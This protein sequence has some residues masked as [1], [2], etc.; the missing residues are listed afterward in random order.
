ML[1]AARRD[2]ITLPETP[3]LFDD[4]FLADCPYDPEVL[5]V[6]RIE[7]IDDLWRDLSRVVVVLRERQAGGKVSQ[8]SH[9]YISSRQAGAEV[10]LGAAG[11]VPFEPTPGRGI[12]GGEG[13][14]GVAEEQAGLGSP[15]VDELRWLRPVYPGDT[16]IVTGKILDKTPS[17]S[18]PDLGSFPAARALRGYGADAGKFGAPSPAGSRTHS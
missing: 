8:E 17:R 3:Y 18:R 11:W 9:Y 12:P 7:E 4:A 1:A 14:T 10:F 15:G 2:V 16:L 6:D 13:Y 5:F